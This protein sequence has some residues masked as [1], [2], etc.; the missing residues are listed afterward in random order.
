MRYNTVINVAVLQ[1]NVEVL[2]TLQDVTGFRY[3]PNSHT[4]K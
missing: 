3:F 1:R 2:E 4:E